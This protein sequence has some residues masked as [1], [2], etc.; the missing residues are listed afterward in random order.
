M[1]NTLIERN[2]EVKRIQV[3]HELMNIGKLEEAIYVNEKIIGVA[4]TVS[5]IHKKNQN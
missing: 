5:N 2:K 1:R 4:F 3:N